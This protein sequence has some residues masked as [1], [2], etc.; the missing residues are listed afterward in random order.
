M[1]SAEIRRRWL[2][3]FEERGHTVVPSASLIADDP[4]LLLVP[5]RHGARSSRT[6]SVRSS[7]P[8]RA[9]T[10]V[11]KCVRT[12]GHRRGRQDH[13]ARHVLPDVRQ[14]LL[15]RLLQGRRHQATPGSCSP[16]PGRGRL[17]PGAREALDHRLP[18]RRRGRARSGATSSACPP[19]A[20]SAWARRT[21]TGPWASRTRAAPAPRSTTTAARSSASRAARPSTTSGYVEIWNLVFMQYERGRGHRQG[22]LRDP[23]RP[24]AARTSTPASVSSASP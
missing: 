5:R 8:S 21:T 22:G 14:L 9:P 18:G 16:A 6:S 15:R 3:F 1:E 24:A 17:R 20:S 4:T 10:S 2:S 12:P 23:R 11:Q 19:S 13:P 7:R